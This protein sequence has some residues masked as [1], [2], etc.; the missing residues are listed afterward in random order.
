MDIN[1][2]S[3]VLESYALSTDKTVQVSEDQSVSKFTIKQS[4]I[5]RVIIIIIIMI[6]ILQSVL[7]QVHNLL[8]SEFSSKC[9]LVFPL[10]CT[11]NYK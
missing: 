9:D 10:E 11:T 6:I 3:N 8:K 2:D 1:E 5:R 4:D 7:R